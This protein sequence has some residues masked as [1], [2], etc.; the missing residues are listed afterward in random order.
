MAPGAWAPEGA[1]R[2]AGGRLTHVAAALA[3][4]PPQAAPRLALRQPRRA[5]PVTAAAA[6]DAAAI[7]VSRDVSQLIGNTPMVYLNR[8]TDGAGGRVAAKLET[9]EPC[10]SVK[11]RIGLSMISEAEKAGK[12]APGQ[13]TLVEPTRCV[14]STARDVFVISLAPEATMARSPAASSSLTHPP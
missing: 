10:C 5:L 3:S 6:T 1:A 14:V 8:V 12:I 2:S 4:P 13:T 7:N 9:M 11:D